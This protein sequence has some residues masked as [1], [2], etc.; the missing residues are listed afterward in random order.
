[1]V[2]HYFFMKDT[3]DLLRQDGQEEDAEWVLSL[4]AKLFPE[5]AAPLESESKKAST[6]HAAESTKATTTE[7]VS[8]IH[9]QV[10]FPTFG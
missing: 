8:R 7:E 1:M 5:L 2:Y 9:E 6:S 3:A 4:A 10:P